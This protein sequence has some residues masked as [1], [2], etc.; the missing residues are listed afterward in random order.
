MAL[1]PKNHAGIYRHYKGGKCQLLYIAK[2]SDTEEDLAIYVSLN[3]L[4]VWVRPA[5][6]FFGTVSIIRWTN[7]TQ[8]TGYRYSY[9]R[10]EKID[11][12]ADCPYKTT[13]GS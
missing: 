12:N 9:L 8:I 7:D 13:S 1:I 2:H 3:D 11:P 6:D 5:T 4:K 10:F